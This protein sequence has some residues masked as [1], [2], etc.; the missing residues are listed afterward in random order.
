MT[1]TINPELILDARALLG[2]G[3]IWDARASVLY[4]VDIAGCKVHIFKPATGGDRAI[5]VGQPVGTVV[6]RR[7]GGVMVALRDGFAALDLDSSALTMIADPEAH[8]P[9]NRFNDGKCDPAGRFWAGTMRQAEDQRGGGSLYRLDPDLSVHKML[10]DVTVANGIAWSSDARTMYFIDTP[11][12]TV[13]AFDYNLETG[14]IANPRPVVHTPDGPGFPDGMTIDAEG[15]LWVAYWGGWRVVRWNPHTGE[16]LA[17]IELPVERVTAPW[18]GG[19]N[20]DEL[21]ITTARVGLNDAG[22]ANQPHAGSIF[23]ARPGVR[24]LAAFDFAG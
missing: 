13:A 17:V 12:M 23:V 20:L 14:D 16:A 11:T 1:Q 2:E 15:M 7:A 6:P 24:G 21:Y 22:L 10:G 19:P 3:P 8:L 4:W 5:D 18:F 9:G